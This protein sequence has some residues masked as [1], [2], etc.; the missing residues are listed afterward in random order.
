MGKFIIIILAVI[1]ILKALSWFISASNR[2]KRYC[3]VIDESKTNVDIALAKRYDTISE[4]IKVAKSFAKH[5]AETLSDITKLRKDGDISEANIMMKNQNDAISRIYAL[6]EAYPDLKSS[7][8]FL[9]LQNEID[10][11]NEKLAAA[12][13]IV[14]SNISKYNQAIVSFPDSII[15]KTNNMEKIDFL[16]EDNIQ[17][18]KSIEHFD[19]NV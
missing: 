1:I 15:A 2:L 10:D 18:K 19:Y 12:K 16:I 11:E 4:M 3:V 6:A 13:R 7:A 5:E 14:N 8:E 17:E 9:N